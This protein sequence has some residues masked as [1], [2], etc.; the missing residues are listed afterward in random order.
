[1]IDPDDLPE[2]HEQLAKV[3][4]AGQPIGGRGILTMPNGTEYSVTGLEISLA[5]EDGKPSGIG[6]IKVKL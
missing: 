6:D 2:E 5:Q 3:L 1:M 4:P